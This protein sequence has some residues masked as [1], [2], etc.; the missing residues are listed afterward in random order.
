MY[1]CIERERMRD[2]PTHI[3]HAYA[4]TYNT[5]TLYTYT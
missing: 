1:I 4:Y 3:T 2:T 5:Y